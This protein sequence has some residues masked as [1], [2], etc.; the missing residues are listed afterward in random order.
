MSH[1]GCSNR[2]GKKNIY[3][4]I[5]IVLTR[6][7]NLIPVYGTDRAKVDYSVLQCAE[8]GRRLLLTHSRYLSPTC[9]VF[10]PCSSDWG[11]RSCV[12]ATSYAFEGKYFVVGAE[13]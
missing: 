11:S 3:I 4:Y 6:N 5:Y 10:V 9:K 13:R 7:G 1:V 8:V 12:L 2:L